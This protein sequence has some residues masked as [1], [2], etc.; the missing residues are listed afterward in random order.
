MGSEVL[1]ANAAHLFAAQMRTL[2]WLI[3]QWIIGAEGSVSVQE[4]DFNYYKQ[5]C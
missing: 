3:A 2:Y 4:Q 5:P 1:E